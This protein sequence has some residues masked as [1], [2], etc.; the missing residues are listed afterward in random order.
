MRLIRPLPIVIVAAL[1]C[2]PSGGSEDPASEAVDPAAVRE[3]IERT[4]A[5][6]SRLLT[7]EKMDSAATFFAADMWQMPPNAPPLVGREAFRAFWSDAMGWGDWSGDLR[8]EEV[9][10]SDSIAVERGVYAMSLEAGPGSPVPSMQ[11]QGNYVVLWQL[12]PDGEWR[13]LWDAPVSELP[14]GGATP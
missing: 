14:P 12:Q 3:T 7:E 1:A 6:I 9:I 8:T 13:I 10:V 4:N 11:D 5:R 2:Q